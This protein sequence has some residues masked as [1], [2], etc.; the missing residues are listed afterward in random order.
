MVT[1][2]A[3]G[4]EFEGA[5]VMMQDIRAGVEGLE[6]VRE[7][8]LRN[9]RAGI[10]DQDFEHVFGHFMGGDAD[11]APVGRKTDGVGNEVVR[12]SSQLVAV[13][14]RWREDSRRSRR[15]V[16]ACSSAMEGGDGRW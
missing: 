3:F 15:P 14:L 1:P 9:A 2:I 10:L 8:L 4:A 11:G 16:A 5:G 13:S 7:V 12:A 6:E